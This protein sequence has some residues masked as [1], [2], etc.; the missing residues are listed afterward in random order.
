MIVNLALGYAFK[1]SHKPS[2]KIYYS[3]LSL[4]LL[5]FSAIVFRLELILLIAP[6]AFQ[7]WFNNCISF[8]RGLMIGITSSIIS[9]MFTVPV[10]TYFWKSNRILWPEFHSL[11]FNVYNNKAIEWGTSPFHSYF[12]LHLPKL[13]MCALPLS[14][15]SILPKSKYLPNETLNNKKTKYNPL[16]ILFAPIVF[17][18]LFSYLKHKEWRFIVY[19]IPL[20][21]GV[22]SLGANRLC[23]LKSKKTILMK[24][25]S[26]IPIISLLLNL[27]LTL[28]LTYISSN[29]YG[30]GELM[31]ELHDVIKDIKTTNGKIGIDVNVGMTGASRFLELDK[32]N[33]WNYLKDMSENDSKQIELNYFLKLKDENDDENFIKKQVKSFNGVNKNAIKFDKEYVL[34]E[35]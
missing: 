7:L 16:S 11:L 9:L 24:L 35:L 4:F 17:I 22:A 2:K 8:K 12:T 32:N 33:G 26:L 25:I 15:I 10:D 18:S 3:S 27:I 19:I 30:G 28:T 34:K 13:L 21:N 1:S 29:N 23:K 20:W 14:I 6:I 5:T 31:I